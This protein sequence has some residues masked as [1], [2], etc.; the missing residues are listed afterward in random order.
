MGFQN[1][2]Y[3]MSTQEFSW[4]ANVNIWTTPEICRS[5]FKSQVGD[6]N[7]R[8]CMHVDIVW[9]WKQRLAKLALTITHNAWFLWL[10][11]SIW[12]YN[13]TS[14]CVGIQTHIFEFL[15][16]RPLLPIGYSISCSASGCL[17]VVHLTPV[18]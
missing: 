3:R 1:K 2:K 9:K 6:G 8:H 4:Q 5:K 17:W 16:R 18:Q 10:N 15:N 14:A 11:F 7:P 13:K 12:N